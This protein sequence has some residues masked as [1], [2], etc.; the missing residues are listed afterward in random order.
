MKPKTK[1]E[2]KIIEW[3]LKPIMFKKIKIF[4]PIGYKTKKDITCMFCGKSFI[5][6]NKCPYCNLKLSII[7]TRKQ[8]YEKDK[9]V[10]VI[11]TKDD[12]QII[13]HFYAV[14]RTKKG[15]DPYFVVEE[16][17]RWVI[18]PRNIIKLLAIASVSVY[19]SFRWILESG[20]EFRNK[21]DYYT[22]AKY[23]IR[24]EISYKK[25]K[26]VDRFK[27]CQYSHKFGFA[28]IDYFKMYI[29]YPEIEM[30]VKKNQI[31]LLNAIIKRGFD[32]S[33]S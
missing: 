32:I 18:T 33:L 31:Y 12:Y 15:H 1:E 29:K 19:Y 8:I 20:L 27:Y 28:T 10:E 3:K 13:R 26:F 23:E 30:I 4:K 21:S 22:A 11:E 2:K 16:V 7:E 6:G 25:P 24:P 5:S 9:Y 17:I 14:L